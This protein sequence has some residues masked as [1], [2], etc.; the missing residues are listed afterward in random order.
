MSQTTMILNDL[1]RSKK[2]T[3]LVALHKYQCLR[4]AAR[5]RDLRDLGYPVRSRIVTRGGKR[6]AEYSLL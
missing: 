3:A 6:V 4:L 2:I 1:K 5:V